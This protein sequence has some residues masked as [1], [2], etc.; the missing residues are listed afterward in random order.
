MA[1]GSPEAAGQTTGDKAAVAMNEP[2]A[3][4]VAQVIATLRLGEHRLELKVNVPAGPTRLDDLMPLLQIL[5]DQVVRT[6][7]EEVV[8][9]GTPISCRKGCGACC[10]QLV[11]ISPVEARHVAAL[12]QSLP[13]A[14]QHVIRQRFAQARQRL[15]AAGMWQKLQ[16]RADWPPSAVSELGLEYFRLGIACPFLEDEACSIHP[17]RPLTC[18]EYLVTS[19]AEYCAAPQAQTVRCVPLP[20]KVWVAAARCEPP[21]AGEAR[22]SPYIPWVPLIQA[23]EW[24]EQQP[25]PPATS[26]GP[27]LVRQVLSA[28]AA[29]SPQAA[30]VPDT[31]PPSAQ[32]AASCETSASPHGQQQP[33]TGPGQGTPKPPPESL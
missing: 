30:S 20:A 17:Q 8:Q 7:E 16:A 15:E 22:P 2:T 27:E 3:D 33:Q 1:L 5:S 21:G 12:V 29:G 32:A 23:L 6:A 9:R 24:A 25:P 13:S 10:R 4:A 18:R 14:R 19:P 26:A 31:A 28:L 11:P